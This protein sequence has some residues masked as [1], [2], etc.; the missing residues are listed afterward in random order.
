MTTP[1]STGADRLARLLRI[2]AGGGG[3]E[4]AWEEAGFDSASAAAG[5]L[6]AHAN[7]LCPPSARKAPPQEHWDGKPVASVI[8]NADGA[9][10]GNPGPAAAAAVA[11][12]AGGRR[13]A[14]V[15]AA[16]G[17]A[18]NNVAEYQACLLA[19]RLA[20]RLGARSV[21]VRMDSDLVVRQL[22]GEFR[23]RNDALRGLADEILTEARGFDGVAWERVPRSGNADADRLANETLDADRERG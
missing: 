6:E 16:I 3:L 4:A 2:L 15:A 12:D 18:T 5:A 17:K 11:F 22:R 1:R 13:L 14:S 7:R 23:I 8:V 19:L 10:R 21:T 9:S 20:A